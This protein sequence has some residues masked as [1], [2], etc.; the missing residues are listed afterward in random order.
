MANLLKVHEQKTIKELAGRGWS[1]R[2]I[3][4]EL[5]IDR[6]TVRRYLGAEAKSPTISTPGSP[7]PAESKSPISTPGKLNLTRQP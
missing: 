1:Q 6:K 7:E 4:A 3:A 5:E 2:A